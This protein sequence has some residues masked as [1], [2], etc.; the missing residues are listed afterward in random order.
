MP[1]ETQKSSAIVHGRAPIP[2][3]V[4]IGLRPSHY[5]AVLD[6]RPKVDWFEVHPE[7]FMAAGGPSLA[8][9]EAVRATHPLSFHSVGLSPGS[10]RPPDPAHLRRF[11]RLVDRFRPAL[12]SDHLAWSSDDGVYM[13]DLLPVPYNGD[14]LDRVVANIGR[15]QDALGR[16]ILIEN[17]SLYLRPAGAEMDEP[18][19]LAALAN[20]T[21]C[22]V[23]L[24]VNNV[25]VSSM[26]LGFDADA[27]ID[28]LPLGVVGEIHLAGHKT[29]TGPYG[30]VRIDDHG[31]VVAD[32]VWRLYERAIRRFGAAPTLI[33][34]DTD[35]PTLDVLIAEAAKARATANGAGRLRKSHAG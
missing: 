32:P 26:N 13:P 34:W 4:G 11:R 22:G 8:M 35:V 18:D 2:T 28:H 15:I 9:L 12:V 3:L 27:Y 25:Y 5:A 19:F 10:H 29:E 23:L 1:V 30:T 17:P 16:P 31:S 7:N 24:D 6:R 33:E 20:R 14:A 21:G